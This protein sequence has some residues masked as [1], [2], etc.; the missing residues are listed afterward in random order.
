MTYITFLARE[1]EG[2]GGVTSFL[3]WDAPGHLERAFSGKVSLAYSKVTDTFKARSFELIPAPGL[4][5]FF[6]IQEDGN[7][8]PVAT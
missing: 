5:F 4:V 7:K 3:V 8:F 6:S 2:E 1:G